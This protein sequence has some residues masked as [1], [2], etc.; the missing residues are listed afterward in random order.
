M[1]VYFEHITDIDYDIIE[2]YKNIHPMEAKKIL[3]MEIVKMYHN[4]SEAIKARQYFEDV[5]S[6]RALM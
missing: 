4:E 5:F 1:F 3:A 2:S 6:K